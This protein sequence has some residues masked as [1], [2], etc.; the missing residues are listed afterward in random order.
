M[1]GTDLIP[2]RETT[3]LATQMEFARAVSSGSILPKAYRDDPGAVLVAINLGSS[4]GL[5]PAE[6]LYRIHVIDGK[7]SASAELIASNVRRAGHRLRIRATNDTATAQ[8]IRSDDP[9]FTYEVTWTIEDA[10]RAK[11]AGKDNWTKH[12]RAMLRARAISEC[13]REA[14]PEA[15]Y[16]VTYVDGEV[17]ESTIHDASVEREAVA[18]VLAPQ[19]DPEAQPEAS[20]GITSAQLKK[21]GALMR[22]ADI[23]DRNVAL[24]YVSDVIGREIG[25]R[26]ELSKDEASKVIDALEAEAS[27]DRTTGEINPP[28]NP[29]FEDQQ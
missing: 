4:M 7:P 8:I 9:D 12:P 11:L 19:S 18:D 16:G 17:I 14:C 2:A 10:Q 29:G 28:D 20:D 27:A 13:A 15:L 25:S 23:T 21:I 3:D 1:T 26:N 22:E 5:S 24:T 6:S